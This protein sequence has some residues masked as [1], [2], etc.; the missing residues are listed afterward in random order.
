MAKQTRTNRRR[1]EVINKP[2]EWI[3]EA[4]TAVMLCVFPFYN[5]DTYFNV[6]ADRADFFMN[7]TVV[8][9]TALMAEGIVRALWEACQIGG[10]NGAGKA[11]GPERAGIPAE[12][13]FL[14]AFLVISTV[15]TY[16]SGHF[17]AA[18]SGS[19]GRLQGLSMW[20]AYG[21]AFYCMARYFRPNKWHLYMFLA[22]GA[23]AAVWGICDYMGPGLEWWLKEVKKEERG[24]FT[25]SIGNIN[26][27][28][29]YMMLCYGMTA[30]YAV[31]ME[32]RN[33]FEKA[34]VAA[35][36]ILFPVA[37]I[38]G[39]SDNAALG[40][41]MLLI[42]LPLGIHDARQMTRYF[43]IL[44]A[45]A[46]A[47]WATWFMTP[48]MNNPYVSGNE[49]IL[50]RFSA[51]NIIPAAV[52]VL[53]VITAV[54]YMLS[55]EGKMLPWWFGRLWAV[56][57]AAACAGFVLVLV[58][59][60]FYAEPG[61]YGAAEVYLKFSDAWGSHRGFCW[62]LAGRTYAEFSPLKKLIGSG[63]ETFGLI[64]KQ[65][66][67][68]EMVET[69]H[70]VFDSPH[71][72]FIQ[73]VFCTGI[74][75]AAAYYAFLAACAF[76]GSRGGGAVGAAAAGAILAYTAVSVVNISVPITQPFVIIL[77]AWCSSLAL[78]R[79]GRF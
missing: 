8:M 41:A 78:S 54:S 46:A 3:M 64:M 71:N 69:C 75:G 1:L 48:Y 62:K 23:V 26:T 18:W 17:G 79:K 16:A 4:Y 25:S 50:L 10:R 39:R 72:E 63:P 60:N 61:K 33:W 68:R 47:L 38:T 58:D 45:F 19:E 9:V 24:S 31:F 44:L 6:L 70:M 74:L 73:Y 28:T 5:T 27:Y 11:V 37:L 43:G 65:E 30:A 57:L 35:A 13:I 22:A 15:S 51:N 32:E 77:A 66:H 67:Y 55:R 12:Y 53:A 20:L 7:A 56:C 76:K 2:R 14:A 29:A 36:A 34:A 21:V 42:A 40:A 49:G 59:A 52:A